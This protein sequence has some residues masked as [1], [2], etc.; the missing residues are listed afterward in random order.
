MSIVKLGGT[1]YKPSYYS[2]HNYSNKS[3]VKNMAKYITRDTKCEGNY[4]CLGMIHCTVD[5]VI[6][7]MENTKKR[8]GKT[9]GRKLIHVMVS[10]REEEYEWLKPKLSDKNINLVLRGTLNELGYT[11]QELFYGH[12]VLFAVHSDT[13]HLHMHAMIN[14][15]NMINGRKISISPSDRERI[16]QFATEKIKLIATMKIGQG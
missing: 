11:L 14:S 9:G 15:V 8:F 16:T 5:E 2:R 7:Q 10:V 3:A 4:G 6:E 13:D 1:D 12:E